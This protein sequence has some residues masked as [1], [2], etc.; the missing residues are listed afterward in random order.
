VRVRGPPVAVEDEE[1]FYVGDQALGNL[2]AGGRVTVCQLP[3]LLPLIS[4][5]FNCSATKRLQIFNVAIQ[6]DFEVK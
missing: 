5:T 3:N 6:A 2:R 4:T 1:G